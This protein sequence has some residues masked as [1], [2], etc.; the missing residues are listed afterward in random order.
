MITYACKIETLKL[1]K[2]KLIQRVEHLQ[3]LRMFILDCQI[4]FML[5]FVIATVIVL[6]L[7]FYLFPFFIG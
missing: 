2:E 4:T 6:I 3:Y 7:L 1:F 5:E